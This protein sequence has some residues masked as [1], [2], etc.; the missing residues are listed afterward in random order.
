MPD[1]VIVATPVMLIGIAMHVVCSMT[2]KM[3]CGVPVVLDGLLSGVVFALPVVLFNCHCV[4]VAWS[5]HQ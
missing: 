4:L 1:T 2:A 3:P 5:D